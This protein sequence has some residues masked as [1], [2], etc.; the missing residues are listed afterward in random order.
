MT[1]VN[2]SEL[3]GALIALG[4]LVC[5]TSPILVYRAVQI[6]AT[7]NAFLFRTHNM[8]EE[9]EFRMDVE[10]T[11]NFKVAVDF[12]FFRSFVKNCRNKN[13]TFEFKDGKLHIDDVPITSVDGEWP[14]A[15]TP[16][17]DNVTNTPLPE[18]FVEVLN[19]AAPQASVDDPRNILKGINLG[20]DGITATNGKELFNAPF[21]FNLDE[22]TIP[23]PLALMATKAS[24]EGRLTAWNNDICVMF[25]VR[26][27]KWRWTA[28]ALPGAYPNWQR[29][30]PDRKDMKHF[31]S[32]TV[33]RADRLRFFLKS[34]ADTKPANE[35]RLYRDAVGFFTLRDGDEH[36]FGIPAEFDSNWGNFAIIVKKDILLHLLGKGHTRIEF[37]DALCPFVGSG[38]IGQYVAMP[39]RMP[40]MEPQEQTA[41]VTQTVPQSQESTT[42]TNTTTTKEKS[43]MIDT[44]TITHT[45]SAKAQTFTP[46]QEP[47]NPLDELLANIEDMKAKSKALFDDSAA[48][49]RKVREVAIAQRQKER[50]YQQTKRTI[51]RIRTAS[52]F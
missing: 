14:V 31:V 30:M 41:Q 4:K 26:I 2:K 29:V 32:F 38:G 35:I 51:E 7:D 5:R 34:V 44:N 18:N 48:M 37:S 33:E 3:A 47:V 1:T 8:T 23:F 13:I 42:P 39:M 21:P 17:G 28:R 40:K 50:E 49:A 27:G 24:G 15:E 25:T 6:E 46:N 20:K 19:Q 43:T 12:D 22:L 11:D 16:Q 52:G 10:T 9:I 36:E 45:V